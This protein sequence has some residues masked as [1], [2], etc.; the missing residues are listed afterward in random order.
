MG[1]SR[2]IASNLKRSA[3]PFSNSISA[4]SEALLKPQTSISAG[5]AKPLASLS[6][7]L[8]NQWSYM[9]THGD[10]GWN[11]FPSYFDVFIPHVLDTL[12]QLDLKI[13][14]FIVGQD[15]ALD[16]NKDALKLLPERGH[17]VGNHSFHHEPWLHLYSK[18]KIKREILETEDHIYRVTGQKPMGF[19]GPGFS[20]SP[21][22]LEILAEN[23]Y[24]YD[25]STLPTYLGPLARMYYFWTS[26]L[27]V[28]EKS[29]RKELFG[30]FKDG[31]KPVEPYSWQLP[32]GNQLLEIPVTTIP[33]I[34][35]PFHLS[36]LIYLSRFSNSLMQFYLLLAIGLCKINGIGPSFLLHPLDLL[37]G[38][39]IPELAFFPGM[40]LTGGQKNEIFNT[41]IN[42]LSKHFS[43]VSMSTHAESIL[44][45]DRLKPVKPA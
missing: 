26:D 8:D 7:D 31:L 12:D 30:N 2:K 20:W 4:S 24:V 17:E 3:P 38:D 34:K 9:K 19:R 14:F 29:Q 41:V 42:K 36:Y 1:L 33:I 25:A 16:K 43:L 18:D 5:S 45:N 32:S 22:L 35:S 13:T 6:L 23:D 11:K 15:A 37:G 39:Q 21:A 40:D 44:K 10:P 27:T 28:E